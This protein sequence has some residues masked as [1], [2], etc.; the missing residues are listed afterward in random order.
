[1]AAKKKRVTLNEFKAW[2]DG[3]EELQPD[4]W[5]PTADQWKLIRTKIGNI[6]EDAPVAIQQTHQNVPQTHNRVASAPT[7]PGFV[8]PP[9][10]GGIPAGEIAM[11]PEAKAMMKPGPDNKQKTPN[12][13]TTDGQYTSSFG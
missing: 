12:I 6:K 7:I 8:P 2:L 9:D 13:D 10:V 1:M 11:S 4:D 5:T 3:V